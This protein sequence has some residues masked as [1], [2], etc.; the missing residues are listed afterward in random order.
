MAP[1]T[2]CTNQTIIAMML[3]FSANLEA[4]ISGL[5]DLDLAR[6]ERRLASEGIDP[7]FWSGVLALEPQGQSRPSRLQGCAVLP[8]GA[9][10]FRYG[11]Y[12]A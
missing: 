10:D 8:H 2:I 6:I 9:N 4:L 5:F 7:S 12:C 1:E 3:R 11:H